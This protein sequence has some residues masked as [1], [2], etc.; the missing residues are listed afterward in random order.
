M[1]TP[2]TVTPVWLREYIRKRL[3]GANYENAARSANIATGIKGKNYARM[4][5]KTGRLI[6][7][8][9]GGA[10]ILKR[11]N[12]EPVLSEHGKWR[13]EHLGALNAAYGK[14]PYYEHLIGEI[15]EI[16]NSSA[17]ETLEEFNRKMLDTAMRWLDVDAYL[18]RK[19]EFESKREEILRNMDDT[20]SIY[21]AIFRLGRET[22]FGL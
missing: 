21:D 3:E 10:G 16:Y 2:L 14:S 11:G 6:V 5:I 1:V 8:V 13:K 17:G 22:I 18:P 20:L 12:S 15:E 9:E 19:R 4:E 7:P